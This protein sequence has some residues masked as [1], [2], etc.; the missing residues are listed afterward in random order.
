MKMGFDAINVINLQVHRNKIPL[1][2][3]LWFKICRSFFSTP[4]LLEYDDRAFMSEICFTRDNAFPSIVPNWDH[5]P[6]SGRKGSVMLGSSP[7]KFQK[8]LH[9]FVEKLQSKPKDKRFVFIKSWN[10]WGEGNYLEPDLKYGHAWL[11]ALK[12]EVLF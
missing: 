1:L 11:D 5:S 4:Q 8:T 7:E 3:R 9:T 12:H 2:R 10:E 6:R